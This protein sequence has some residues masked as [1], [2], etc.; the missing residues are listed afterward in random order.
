MRSKLNW[1][2][3]GVKL[4]LV[5][6]RHGNRNSL[7]R[8]RSK[9]G[10]L[11]SQQHLIPSQLLPVKLFKRRWTKWAR[12]WKFFG[13][14]DCKAVRSLSY[15]SAIIGCFTNSILPMAGS[16]CTTLVIGG[17]STSGAD[18]LTADLRSP[19]S[20]EI[21]RWTLDVERLLPSFATPPARESFRS[22]FSKGGITRASSP[23][24]TLN[25]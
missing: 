14:S 10:R 18:T 1:I 15:G 23:L 12:G 5:D 20:S 24:S 6:T 25:H 7:W 16:I 22:S 21:G 4:R 9:F 3:P 19:P 13:T 17:K 2:S 8:P 11:R